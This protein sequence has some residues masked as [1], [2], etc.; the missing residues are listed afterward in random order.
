MILVKEEGSLEPDGPVSYKMKRL[1]SLL[2]A[3][4]LCFS[5]A[6]SALA[7]K[8]E[9]GAVPEAKPLLICL[10]PGHGARD[11]G[12][13]ATYGG[14]EYQEADLVL[15]IALY[16]RAEL[17]TYQDVEVLM[18]RTD[19]QGTMPTIDPNKIKPRTDF[20]VEHGAD[21]M[22]SLH[23]NASENTVIQGAMIL[24]SNGYYRREIAE[25]GNGLGTDIL[26]ALEKL[27]LQNRGHLKTNSS[28]YRN[29]NGTVADYYAIVRNGIWQNIPSIIVE[30]CFLTNAAD[31]RKHL[32]SGE[33]LKALA[34]ADAEGI[35]AYYGLQKKDTLARE[36]LDYSDHWAAESI[37]AAV[38]RGWVNGYPDHTFRPNNT[39]TRADFVT[40]L[41]RLSAEEL[42]EITESPFPDFNVE[43]YYASSVAWAVQAGIINGFEDGTFGPNRPV[44]REQMAHIMALYLKHKGLETA[45][46][47]ASTAGIP[48]FEHVQPYARDDVLY[49]YENGLLQGR[50]GG[51][52]PQG[53]ATRAEACTIL[54][55][56]FD[57]TAT[58]EALPMEP[59]EPVPFAEPPESPPP[60]DDAVIPDE[61]VLTNE[62]P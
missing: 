13:V 58:H 3:L 24:S 40:L 35:A 36:L 61:T 28:D 47:G 34:L 59:T 62:N 44:T 27:G 52:V 54:L 32:S 60:N 57:Y 22:V 23:L 56:L 31:F 2:L 4:V 33:K 1:L 19:R 49:C 41:A 50:E 43:M 15:Q 30:H 21:V 16:L 37:D 5:L 12:A 6:M 10:D 48:D 7:D 45:P 17:E 53:N 51:F 55:R 29:P 8:Q 9:N 46:E 11:S 38:S 20:A 14:V 42:P 26:L 25:I 18:T 39:L